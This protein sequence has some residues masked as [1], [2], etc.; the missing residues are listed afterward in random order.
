MGSW[1]WSVA[2]RPPV[3]ADEERHIPALPKSAFEAT[4]HF[5]GRTIAIW[6]EWCFGAAILAA[7]VGLVWDVLVLGYLPDPFLH[8]K[9]DTF[10]DWYNPA[11]WANNHGVYSEW[12]SIYPPFSFVFVRLFTKP[13]CYAYSVD[14]ARGC[15]PTGIVVL[16]VL[17]IVN[18]ILAWRVF[19]KVDASTALP[20]ALA[21]GLGFPVLYAWERGNLIVPCF[22]AFIL[23]YGN[24]LKSARLKALFAAI[25]LN[26]KP[27]LILA[28]A[29]RAVKRDWLWLEW[30]G[31]TFVAIYSVSYVVIGDGGPLTIA[32]N[33]LSFAHTPGLDLIS[34]TTTYTAILTIL[35]QPWPMIELIGSRPVEV[36]EFLV[37]L[38][39][40]VGMIGVLAC[41]T[42]AT[43]R[44]ASFTRTRFS[45]L[46][47][48]LFMS[49]STVPGGYSVEYAVFFV[50]YERWRGL[51]RILALICAYLWCIPYDINFT[52]IYHDL[53]YSFLGQR[54]VEYELAISWGQ[55]LRPGLLLLME[56]GLVCAAA[57]DIIRDLRDRR[58][59]MAIS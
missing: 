24:L 10:N 19:R 30:C 2:K 17:T 35:D 1:P 56:Y 37:P 20:R 52:N 21:V 41:L 57:A 29:G 13:E 16:T 8:A 33:V 7:L 9:A 39:I 53:G 50:F 58:P 49:I 4:K 51:G 18:F 42:Y 14:S 22:T 15:D 5:N 23:A 48:I 6:I 12:R 54:V 43:W 59:T 36:A 47:L 44:P 3:V 40:Y 45:A 31:L 28:L 55:L 11:Y 27:Y 34:F 46:M 25:S 38:P 26:F 32:R